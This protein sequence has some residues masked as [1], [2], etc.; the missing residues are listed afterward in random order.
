MATRSLFIIVLVP[1]LGLA[2]CT[3]E[4]NPPAPARKP[5]ATVIVKPKPKVLTAEQ[6]SELGFP[7]DMIAQVE[8]AAEAAAEPFFEHVTLKSSNLKGDVMITTGRLAGFSVRTQKADE[9]ITGLS[10]SLRPRG[11]L[12]FR[13][14]QNFGRVPDIVS[15]VRGTSSYDIVKVQQTESAN[16]RL[17]TKA[18]IAWLRQQQGICSFV[19]TGAGADWVEARFIK[20]PRD[21]KALARKIA[22]F[23]P[24]V[25]REGPR[26]VDKLAEQMASS[27]GFRL[28]WD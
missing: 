17:D 15:V 8:F 26:T 28:V 19:I 4:G 10:P 2:S 21:M 25:L 14:R 18:I 5:S 12:I 6:R 1:V 27:N 7:E 20:P 16:Y 3:N 13:S 11:Y 24:D 22:A 9:V 23:A